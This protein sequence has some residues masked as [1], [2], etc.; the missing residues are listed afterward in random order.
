MTSRTLDEQETA[1]FGRELDALRDE[2]RRDL[3]AKD[4]AHIRGVIRF[5]RRA[6]ATGRLLL[7]FGV[8]PISF[9]AGAIALGTAKILDNMEIGHN[10]M[11]GQYDWTRDPSLSGHAYDWDNVCAAEDWRH[12]HNYEHHT[13]TNILGKDRDIGYTFLRVAP[14]QAWNA[15]HVFQPLTAT[16][17]AV[18]FEWGVATHDLRI[19]ETLQGK[20][21]WKTLWERSGP[22][23]KKATVQLAKDYV[24]FPVLALGNAPRVFLGNMTANVVRNLWTFAIIFCGHFPEGVRI[25]SE[26]EAENESRGDWY[27]RQ[28]NG[29]ANIE[30]SALFHVMSGHLSH[31]IEHHLF[32]DI[33]ASRYP[34]MAPRVRAICA[35][36]GQR[37]NT[38]SFRRQLG[39]VVK[40]LVVNA[41]PERAIPS[42]IGA[43]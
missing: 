34:E 6:D 31:Q 16:T 43:A 25:Y 40:R 33:P 30:G 23:A 21:S 19:V 42:A 41:L 39:S 8:D 20:Q 32:P 5:A 14:E 11:H 1:E 7:H 4:V 38:G 18:V 24:V 12:S 29:S 22:F 9:V 26:K 35:K 10:I 28:L 15:S 17:L 13:F 27:L 2:V 3:G 36:Y 37:Y